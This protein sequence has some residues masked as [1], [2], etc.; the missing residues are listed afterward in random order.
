MITFFKAIKTLFFQR[1]DL[2]D[3]KNTEYKHTLSF[4]SSFCHYD[5]SNIFIDRNKV[6][7][8][9]GKNISNFLDVTKEIKRNLQDKESS[10]NCIFV[11][12]VENFHFK[13]RKTFEY[14]KK[15]NN[16]NELKMFY[17]DAIKE[18]RI[19]SFLFTDLIFIYYGIEKYQKSKPE[20]SL[21]SQENM[22][23]FI[24]GLIFNSK[25]ISS[26]IFAFEEYINKD[27]LITLDEFREII[28][29]DFSIIDDFSKNFDFNKLS[30]GANKSSYSYISEHFTSFSQ[31]FRK[32][33]QINSFNMNIYENFED[34]NQNDAEQFYDTVSKGLSQ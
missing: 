33:D 19:F 27:S 11:N 23:F 7:Y 16:N 31:S 2:T 25:E 32:T 14:Y 24:L 4:T 1:I 20:F 3:S 28:K 9:I 30:N 22:H 18:L 34:N 21:Y 5:K 26:L 10:L 29:K 6:N 17:D 15:N 8:E 13:H 12:F